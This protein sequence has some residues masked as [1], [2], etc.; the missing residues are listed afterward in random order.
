M[1]PSMRETVGVTMLEAMLAGCVPIVADNGGP[2]C[3]V[4]EECGFKIPVTTTK[5]MARQIA[6]II[7][8]IDRDRSILSVK[9]LAASTRVGTSFTAENYRKR[10]NAVY[11]TVAKEAY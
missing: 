11:Q 3:T 2:R 4:T 8:A 6:E 1:L 10:V 7:V 5:E 9:G